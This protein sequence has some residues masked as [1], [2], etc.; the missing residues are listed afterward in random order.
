MLHPW[1]ESHL[2]TSSIN[3]LIGQNRVFYPYPASSIEPLVSAMPTILLMP[4]AIRWGNTSS[5]M[6]H[7]VLSLAYTLLMFPRNKHSLVLY[8]PLD[9]ALPN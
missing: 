2:S 5:S 4:L 3:I 7:S 6:Y 1:Y 9:K 8:Q